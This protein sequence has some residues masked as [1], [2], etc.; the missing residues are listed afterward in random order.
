MLFMLSYHINDINLGKST[1][2]GHEVYLDAVYNPTG[3]TPNSSTAPIKIIF[4]KNKYH[5][6]EFSRYEVA[7]T[8]LARLFLA[9]GLTANQSL[10]INEKGT[11]LGLATEHMAYVIANKEGLT[12]NFYT[13]SCDSLKGRDYVAKEVLTVEHI[14]IHFLDKLPQGFFAQLLSDEREGLV[15]VDYN[16]LASL[17][18]TSYTLEEDDLHKGNFGFYLIEKKGKPHAVFFKIDHD[19]MMANSVMSFHKI[20]TQQIF[21]N[22]QAFNIDVQDLLKFPTILSE[23]NYWPARMNNKL[24]SWKEKAYIS[25]EEVNAFAGLSQVAEFKAAKWLSLYKHILIPTEL[26]QLVLSDSTDRKNNISRAETAL[27]THSVVARQAHLRAALF[28]LPEFRDFIS[29]LSQTDKQTLIN[30]ILQSCP[31]DHKARIIKEIERSFL[32]YQQLIEQQCFEAGDTP[33]H[34]AIKLGDF[35]YEETMG[36]YGRYT[37]VKNQSG[38][39]ALNC[40]LA[41]V[42][43]TEAHPADIRRD[44]IYTMKCLLKHGAT[45]SEELKNYAAKH[46]FE[47]YQFQTP[48]VRKA[49]HINTYYEL[50]FLLRDI[51]EE[52]SYCLKSKKQLAVECV[53][54]FIIN[55]K[56]NP[57]LPAYLDNL[58]KEIT[59][60]VPELKYIRQLRSRLWVVRQI[61]GLYGCTTTQGQIGSLIAGYSKQ[62]KGCN[63]NSF[64]KR[65]LNNR[66][67]IS[68]EDPLNPPLRV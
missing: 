8:Q 68:R 37:N 10:V 16:S 44:P 58:K 31:E 33:L 25:K 26:T 51:G 3:T 47:N 35:R 55:N 32:F 66:Q 36:M 54:Q 21:F 24:W 5:R 43:F 52:H 46:K 27:I 62:A 15:S 59:Q 9:P 40:A 41:R 50:K 34:A 48:L 38:Q 65:G 56:T 29:Q 1:H 67:G 53:R 64:F 45:P 17:L 18:T 11:I 28:S 63:N 13:Y 19:L 30:E 20:R 12:Q 6:S 60:E 4:K 61:R 7:F 23:N 39:T 14:P 22:E 2:A 42:P 57:K 49:K